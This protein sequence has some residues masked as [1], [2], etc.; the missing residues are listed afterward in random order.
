MITTVGIDYSL[1]HTG[2]AALTEN[3]HQYIQILQT[4]REDDSS[5]YYKD[6]TIEQ[7]AKRVGKILDV[8]DSIPTSYKVADNVIPVGIDFSA[9][10]HFN[11]A[12]I[13]TAYTSFAIGLLFQHL[14]LSEKFQPFIIAPQELRK[15]VG[16]KGNAKKEETQ[17][18]YLE[19]TYLKDMAG[20]KDAPE[21]TLDA[22]IIA[23]YV[24]QYRKRLTQERL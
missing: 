11:S 12:R 15:T 14:T 16:L 4:S 23:W 8:F 13:Q 9:L 19:N 10:V 7:A 22:V 5:V 20:L 2:I 18:W 24:K 6:H 21:D 3:D 17:N 1:T